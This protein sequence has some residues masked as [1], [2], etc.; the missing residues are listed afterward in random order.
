MVKGIGEAIS[1]SCK[2]GGKEREPE[3]KGAFAISRIALWDNLINHY[4]KAY[5]HALKSAEG[6]EIVYYEKERIEKLPETEQALV[7][8]HPFWRRVLVQQ[9]I[10]DKLKP[11]E[12]LSRNLW[13]SWTQ[14]AIDLFASIDPEL[15]DE[16]NE[17]PMELLEQ[18]S[19]E[20]MK[21]LEKDQDSLEN[22][23][24]SMGISKLYGGKTERG[25]SHHLLFQHGIWHT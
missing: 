15:W 16:V 10:P 12:E 22:F 13:W 21:K 7:D 2:H 5:D 9:N 17:N 3:R 23:R 19:Y 6:K 8:I 24:K 25:P 4:W 11:L 18:L 1:R 14:D 20:T